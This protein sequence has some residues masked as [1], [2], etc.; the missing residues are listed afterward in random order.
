MRKKREKKPATMTVTELLT[1]SGVPLHVQI[2]L[3][4]F[5]RGDKYA[6][7][8]F[9][10]G[11]D[12]GV[13]EAAFLVYDTLEARHEGE[14]ARESSEDA[15]DFIEEWLYTLSN[16][17]DVHVWNNADAAV[18]VL[19]WFINIDGSPAKPEGDAAFVLL[20]TAVERLTTKSERR[21]FLR[22]DADQEPEKDEET[23]Q[24]AAFKLARV[25]ADPRT[26]KETRRELEYALC[27]F[28][29]AADVQVTHPALARRAFQLMCEAKP[30]GKAREAARLRV[31]L[32]GLLDSISEERG[33]DE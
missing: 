20:R 22:R 18:T 21:A 3:D 16:F 5:A 25:L 31:A 8:K 26:D 19:P 10:C 17:Y 15:R 11:D 32:L 24:R 28:A 7:E 4:R 33:G 27:E 9:G 30:K 23:D 1:T 13:N 2:W 14:D 6:L 12:P 29:N